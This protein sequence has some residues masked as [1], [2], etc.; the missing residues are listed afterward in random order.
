MALA[1]RLKTADNLPVLSTEAVQPS[2]HPT[3]GLKP[4]FLSDGAACR[5]AGRLLIF[6]PLVISYSLGEFHSRPQRWR[7]RISRSTEARWRDY[8]HPAVDDRV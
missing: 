1:N 4:L 7:S 8:S 2:S 6:I 5:Q 3:F